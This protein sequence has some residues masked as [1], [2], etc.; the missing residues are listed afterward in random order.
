MKLQNSINT[1]SSH[2]KEAD[3]LVIS[4]GAGMGVDSGLPDF[5]GN[6]GFWNEY[7][8]IKKLGISFSEMAN[9]QWFYSK[10]KLAWAFYGHRLNLYRST[11]PHKGYQIL[12]DI[13]KRKK[14][15][16]FA[17]T[18]NVDGH[19]QKAGY[20]EKKVVECHGSINH[21]QCT[22]P[23]SD[24]I[25]NAK[26]EIVDID[27]TVFEAL[28]PI[29]KCK[30]C[31]KLARPNVL[32]FGDWHWISSRTQ[33]QTERFKK[34]L[35]EMGD[36]KIVIIEIGAGTAVPTVRYES[37]SILNSNNA[38][39]VRINPRDSHTSPGQ[40]SITLNG[41]EGIKRITEKL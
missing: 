27:M 36:K 2:I 22:E 14:G 18:S 28:D 1:A 24:D 40:T 3:A 11:E 15:E 37:E 33:R 29:P 21:F 30:N 17:F 13:A 31:D 16:Y 41:L 19:F 12:L 10:P 23:C 34:W 35:F 20:D 38:H 5:R 7:P 32:M 39:L 6:E 26:K 4:T 9:P 25:W 8:P